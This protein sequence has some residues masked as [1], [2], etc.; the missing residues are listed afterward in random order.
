MSVP[1]SVVP[2]KNSTLAMVPSVSDAFAAIAIVA[3]A[4]KVAP[5]AG[6]VIDTDGKLFA[7]GFTVTETAA[8]VFTPP[9]S[10]VARAVSEYV[11]AATPAHDH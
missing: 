7:A 5:D 6:L 3:G 4:V 8:E 9:L 10:S 1:S 11:P 2:D